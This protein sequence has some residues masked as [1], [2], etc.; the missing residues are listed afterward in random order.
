MHTLLLQHSKCIGAA[1][2]AHTLHLSDVAHMDRVQP[3]HLG[4]DEITKHIKQQT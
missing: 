4:I 1:Q 2:A 3:P